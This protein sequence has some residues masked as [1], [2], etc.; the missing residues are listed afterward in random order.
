[1]MQSNQA[2]FLQTVV[3]AAPAAL[4]SQF[5]GTLATPNASNFATT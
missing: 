4:N 2:E 5:D 1:M 3:V